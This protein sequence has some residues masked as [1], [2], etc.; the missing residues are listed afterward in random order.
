VVIDMT[1][2]HDVA[3][4]DR[5]SSRYDRSVLQR[6]FFGPIQE[7][8]IAEAALV[9]H[10]PKAVLDVGCGTGQLLRRL[11]NRY[12]DADLVGVDPSPG[13]IRQAQLASAPS[14]H[15]EFLNTSA[16]NLPF[17]DAHF[18]LVLTTLSFHHWSDQQDGLREI[19]RVLHD[20][21][22]FVLTD[23]LAA[24]WFRRFIARMGQFHAPDVLDETLAAERLHT[25]LRVS[26]PWPRQVKVTLA[27]A[28][29]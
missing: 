23:V 27:R 21:G 26:V 12:P 13:M 16:E 28:V 10:D 29:T 2:D 11:A 20:S 25:I 18:D 24:G 7:A 3:H 5:W 15:I 14:R 22:V 8:T 6:F 17:P 1:H 4:F 9:C 19:R